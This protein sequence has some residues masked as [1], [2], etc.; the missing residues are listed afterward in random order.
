[1]RNGARWLFILA[2]VLAFAAVVQDFRFDSSSRR[3]QTRA[4]DIGREVAELRSTLADLRRGQTAYLATGQGPEFWTRRV[5]DQISAIE[6]GLGRLRNT[7][8]TAEALAQV[9]NAEAALTSLVAI[10]KRAREALEG[11]QRFLASDIVFAEGQAPA[12]QLAD[13]LSAAGLAEMSALDAGSVRNS[14]VRLAMMAGAL[15]LVII[16]GV[17]IGQSGTRPVAPASAAQAMA[18]MLRELPPPV[19]NPLTPAVPQPV[20]QVPPKPVAPPATVVDLTEAAELCVDL[21][22]VMDARDV[23]TLLSRSAKTLNASGVVVW[24]VTADGARLQPALAHGYS[25]K[26]VAKL[27]SLEVA[28]DNMTSVCFRTMKPQ[29]MSGIGQ[30]GATSAIAVPLITT[31]GCH[32]VMAAELQVIKPA[33]ESIALARILAAQF[34]TMIRPESVAEAPAGV[35][36]QVAEG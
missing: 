21:A 17:V 31:D 36:V 25:S 2:C 12:Q 4:L 29:S 27:G 11:D 15:L 8:T 13:A 33:S 23:P 14:R 30:P 24:V 9:S 28:G 22:R 5:A 32:G 10:D 34:A 3:D 6:S 19:K 35:D 1:M 16:A 7:L 20:V 26:V 18:Q